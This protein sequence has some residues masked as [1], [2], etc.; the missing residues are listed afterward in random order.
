MDLSMLQ[1]VPRWVFALFAALVALGMA[2]SLP[3]EVGLR[4]SAVLPIVLLALSLAGVVSSFAAVALALPAWA[5]GVAVAVA[6]LHGRV[7]VAGVRYDAVTQ[8]FALP[9]SWIPLALMM[10]LFALKFAVG[11]ALARNP[12]LASSVAFASM[13][14]AAYGLFSGAFLGRAMALWALARRHAMPVLRAG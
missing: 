9:G 13:A 5:A 6:G 10:S 2:Q 14:S 12:D 11:M 4:R 7:D 3:R 1:Y 8:R